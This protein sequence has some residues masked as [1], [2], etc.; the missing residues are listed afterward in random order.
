MNLG[1]K[2]AVEAMKCTTVKMSP[3][4]Y[5]EIKK[6]SSYNQMCSKYFADDS[7]AMSNDFPNINLLRQHFKGHAESYGFFVDHKGDITARNRFAVFGNS[8]V[9]TIFKDYS[10][11]VLIVRHNSK[12]K[13]KAA[14]NTFLMVNILDSASVEI[15]AT[16]SSKVIVYQY[17][18]NSKVKQSGNV[19][20]KKR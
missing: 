20:V 16:D 2:L 18:S 14:D 8:D 19:E 7:W 5:S 11:S 13:I 4:C 9:E 10:V 15:E 17:G 12:M 6:F 3:E 1:K